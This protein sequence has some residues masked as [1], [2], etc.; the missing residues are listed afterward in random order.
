MR[1]ARLLTGRGAAVQ[2]VV[3]SR[4]GCAVC[5]GGGWCC[6][7]GGELYITG[8]DIITPPRTWQTGEKT[9][10]CPKLRFRVV[11]TQLKLQNF[12][13]NHPSSSMTFVNIHFSHYCIEYHQA[14][15]L[16][17]ELYKMIVLFHV[18]GAISPHWN[19]K[20]R[21]S[22]MRCIPDTRFH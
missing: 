9:L 2:G 11:N 21:L 7:G 20:Q 1:T 3:L 17:K 19:N 8:S 6:P 12:N 4:D 18:T 10:P 15:S 5:D 14:I 13:C 16:F 22:S